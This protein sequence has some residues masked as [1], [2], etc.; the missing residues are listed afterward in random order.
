MNLASI[1]ENEFY[2]FSFGKTLIIEKT[3]P[4]RDCRMKVLDNEKVVGIAFR[5]SPKS[6]YEYY[7]EIK[8]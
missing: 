7:K 2:M 6:D 4:D 5:P 3:N 1:T 8:K